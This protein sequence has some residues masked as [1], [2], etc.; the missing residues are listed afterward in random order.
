MPM[1]KVNTDAHNPVEIYYEDHGIGKPIVLI[2][3]WP[4]P[5]SGLLA[6]RHDNP[7]HSAPVAPP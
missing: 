2:H 3:G 5:A 6:L 4:P 1:L 7:T